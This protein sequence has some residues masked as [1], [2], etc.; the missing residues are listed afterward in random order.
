MFLKKAFYKFLFPLASLL[1]VTSQIFAQDI[2]ADVPANIPTYMHGAPN[3]VANWV[4]IYAQM[5]AEVE[6]VD[7]KIEGIC[8]DGEPLWGFRVPVQMVEVVR[9]VGETMLELP[10]ENDIE[11][12]DYELFYTDAATYLKTKIPSVDGPLSFDENLKKRSGIAP[13]FQ[14][15]ATFGQAHVYSLPT[16][17]MPV[18]LDFLPPVCTTWLEYDPIKTD[19]YPNQALWRFPDFTYGAL[20]GSE[21]VSP[22]DCA[23]YDMTTGKTQP[24]LIDV[25]HTNLGGLAL[26]ESTCLSAWGGTVFPLAGFSY[27][28]STYVGDLLRT[29]KAIELGP[30]A[31]ILGGQYQGGPTHSINKEKDA[32]KD[33][34]NGSSCIEYGAK[35]GDDFPNESEEKEVITHYVHFQKR[36]CCY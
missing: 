20:P 32:F 3:S 9:N 22:M 27:A 29:V 25:P 17:Y 24:G 36:Y 14:E 8:A 12:L 11:Y 15:G 16:D 5:M 35:D 30:Y 28:A 7:L 6:C 4:N 2:T 13:G 1:I 21:N 34:Y 31:Q 26:A 18:I 10:I 19:V 23:F 33:Y